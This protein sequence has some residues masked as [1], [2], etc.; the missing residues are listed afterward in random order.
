MNSPDAKIDPL[1]KL[2]YCTTLP[3]LPAIALKIIELANDPGADIVS[4]CK[5]IS[6]D[7]ALSAKL[8]KTAN[9]PLYKTR[10]ISTN[11]RQAVSILGTH[12]V[13]VIAL[14]F[15]LANSF[16][17]NPGQYSAAFDNNLFWRRSLTSALASRILGEKLGLTALDDLFLAALLQEIGILAFSAIM[18]DEYGE[19][20]SSTTDHDVLLQTE[21]EQL[22]IGH[23]ELGYAL[24]KQWHIPDHISLACIASHNKPESYKSEPT[25]HACVAVS[26]YLADFFLYPLSPDNKTAL[27]NAAD[28]WL[29]LDNAAVVEIIN[30][31][32]DQLATVEE[33]FDINIQSS[34]EIS[35]M[36]T[37]AKELLMIH[38]LS[39]VKELEEKSQRDGLTG[40]HNRCYFDVTLQREFELSQ[41]HDLPLTIAMIDLDHFKRVNDTYGHVT[42]DSVLVAAVQAIYG[43]I[44]HDDS[45]C[46]YGG[47]EFALILPSTTIENSRNLIARL[48]D[49]ITKI[50][51]PSEDGSTINVTVSI[52]VASTQGSSATFRQPNDLI[53]AADKAL[54]A[55]KHNGRNRIVEWH[56]I[57]SS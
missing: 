13:I 53:K 14:S 35:G 15:S 37:Q 30:S 57:D 26:R 47:E 45:L 24:L 19:I 33:L 9:S 23:D 8:L 46:R 3:T 50:A 51:Y 2:Q 31:M 32:E 18:P 34:L 38:S 36:M 5:Y 44:R 49:N 12:T 1:K 48:K 6:M 25:L 21:Q 56:D 11:I 43:Q 27:V 39:K 10:R 22:G 41:K 55:A 40:A 17:K 42:G 7:P 28:S 4:A 20:F 52:G 29:N 16:I 54:Y